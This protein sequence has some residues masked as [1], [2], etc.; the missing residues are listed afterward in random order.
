MLRKVAVGRQSIEAYAESSG[1]EAVDQLR[2][3][4]A[5]L[6]DARVLHLNATP[7]GG[8]VAEILRS[9]VPL[10]RDLG[11]DAEWRV[12]AGNRDFFEVT[13]G[14]HN[15]LQGAPDS[16]SGGHPQAYLEQSRRNAAS[17]EG[18]YDLVVAH[19]PQPLALVAFH[20]R[21]DAHWIWRCHVDTSAPD[22]AA[23]AFVRPYLADY[24]AAVFTLGG[25]APPDLDSER[26]EIIPP[27]I[28]PRS[29]KN[30]EFPPQSARR[31]LEWIGVDTDRPLVSQISRFDPW[32]DPLGVV[33]AFRLAREEVPDLRLCLVGSMALDDPEAWEVH[34]AVK[35]ET[36]ADGGVQLFTNLT[37]VGNLEVN[38]FQRLSDVIV[39]KSIREGFG[40]V[41]SEALWK[42]TPVVAGKAGGIP[43][44]MPGEGRELLVESVEECAAAILR[45]LEDRELARTVGEAGRA[46]VRSR[47]LLPRLIAD[48]LRLYGSLLER[49]EETSRQPSL[50]GIRSEPRDPVCGMRLESSDVLTETHDGKTYHFCSRA[51]RERFADDPE[52][53]LRTAP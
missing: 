28:D 39:Q 48:E 49:V 50:A 5:P 43:V 8:G 12:I 34:D 31:I 41:V 32:K 24:D 38:A 36:E 1:A 27:A 42:R 51:C 30:M 3:L 21:G 7:Y 19:D 52:K 35:E 16:F 11:L 17:L 14:L 45:L 10:L 13:K 29:P 4:A 25:F 22:P 46:K 18:D 40:L 6:R 53:Y 20:G 9:E 44:Q 2:E 37:G 33:D 26:T 23:W 47:F 15:G